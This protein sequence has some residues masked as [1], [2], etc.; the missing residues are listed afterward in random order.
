MRTVKVGKEFTGFVMLR[1]KGCKGAK[2][3]NVS[4]TPEGEHWFNAACLKR[5]NHTITWTPEGAEWREYDQGYSRILQT[6]CPA[7]GRALNVQFGTPIYGSFSEVSVCNSRCM[8]ATS[9]AC[10]CSCSGAN[11]GGGHA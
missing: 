6:D 9:G 2:R 7:C 8:G 5:P 3:I 10:E 11:H 4:G 1:H